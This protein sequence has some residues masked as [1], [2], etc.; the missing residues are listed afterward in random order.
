MILS[1]LCLNITDGTH[2][3]VIDDPNGSYYLLSCKNI[4]NGSIIITKNER[5]INKTVFLKLN[6]RTK[7][8]FNDILI[9]TVGTIG[10]LAIIKDK[11]IKYE[12]QRS[13]GIIKVNPNIM[14]PKYVYY[15]LNSNDAQFQ[16]SSYV[17]GAVQK[18]LFL[19]DIGKI[20]I[21]EKSFVEQQHIVDIVRTINLILISLLPY[22]LILYFF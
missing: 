1:K 20:D 10:Q 5:K 19:N 15:Y 22:L 4:K 9:T 3:T 7:L 6:K 17:K 12:F 18:C 16:I 14:L 8:T 13:V 2:N 11:E 21:F